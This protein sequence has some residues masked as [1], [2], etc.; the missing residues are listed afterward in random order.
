V[1]NPESNSSEGLTLH[2]QAC[3]VVLMTTTSAQAATTTD[4]TAEDAPIGI[5]LWPTTSPEYASNFILESVIVTRTA[6]TEYV[7]WIYE[8]GKTRV[9]AKGEKVACQF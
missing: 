7:T 9:F 6:G 5:Q 1:S 2:S 4:V 3:N 8:N